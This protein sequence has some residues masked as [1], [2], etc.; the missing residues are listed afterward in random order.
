MFCVTM[1]KKPEPYNL[2]F[3]PRASGHVSVYQHGNTCNFK[4]AFKK[5]L[6]KS[7]K[8]EKIDLKTPLIISILIYYPSSERITK[9]PDLDNMVKSIIDAGTGIIYEDDSQ[10]CGI[11]CA[12]VNN[13][14]DAWKFQVIYHF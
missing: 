9:K 14:E 8:Q 2:V 13:E 4:N 11:S 7:Y 5:V 12:K 1:D 10:I 3:F 6:K